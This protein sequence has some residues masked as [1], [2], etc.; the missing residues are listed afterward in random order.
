MGILL[1]SEFHPRESRILPV[2]F[3]IS[4]RGNQD[5]REC[6]LTEKLIV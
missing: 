2:E 5:F 6:F 1:L 3:L 4:A